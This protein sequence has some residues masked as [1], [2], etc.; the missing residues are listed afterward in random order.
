MFLEIKSL[1]NNLPFIYINTNP[2]VTP[3]FNSSH[4]ALAEQKDN[5]WMS[6]TASIYVL[7][8]TLPSICDAFPFFWSR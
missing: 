3:I 5:E 1:E 2:Q 6:C 4:P 7:T 8:R